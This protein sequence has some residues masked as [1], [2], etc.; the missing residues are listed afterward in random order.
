MCSAL[1]HDLGFPVQ[2][3]APLAH[4]HHAVPL[5]WPRLA[6][7]HTRAHDSNADRHP[8]H[9]GLAQLDEFDTRNDFH[10]DHSV[11]LVHGRHNH[12]HCVVKSAG[13][14][15]CEKQ[16]ILVLEIYRVREST[17]P[18]LSTRLRIHA[19]RSETHLP[20]ACA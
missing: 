12:L 4:A 15:F 14:G 10:D 9:S 3:S 2:R 18:A 7:Q 5:S 8:D 6:G 17:W 1:G 11:S 13:L 20:C 19:R 16:G